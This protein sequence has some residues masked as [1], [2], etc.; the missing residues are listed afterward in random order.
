MG[1]VFLRRL[2]TAALLSW[3]QPI[4]LLASHAPDRRQISG[5]GLEPIGEQIADREDQRSL[6]RTF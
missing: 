2:S 3:P 4:R 5:Y 6:Y 1:S